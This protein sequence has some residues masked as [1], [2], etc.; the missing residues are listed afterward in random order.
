MIAAH[1]TYRR[2]LVID[3]MALARR[4]ARRYAT[5]P[6]SLEELNQVACLGLVKA[7]DRYDPARGTTLASFAIPTILGE[8]KRHFR[9]AR[10]AARVPREIQERSVWLERE[11]D[12]LT[13]RLGRSPRPSELAAATG[14][15]VEL[16]LEALE[17]SRSRR[18]A[19][20]DAP[21]EQDEEAVTSA[22]LLGSEDPSYA[23][24]DELLTL[25]AALRELSAR[26]RVVLRLRYVEELSQA[27]I[28]QHIGVSQMQV[29]R[30]LRQALAKLEESVLLN[31][32]AS[33]PPTRPP[34]AKAVSV[35]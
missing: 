10:W 11:L 12:A 31:P 27:D 4:L 1:D 6:Q 26:E 2:Q 24:V 32:A 18:A 33:G 28:G 7:V 3:H 20:L 25:T 29:S 30:L 8:L 35:G 22:D 21:V 34:H 17:A 5:G 13:A 16:V 9:D 19:S 14:V 15:D 23:A